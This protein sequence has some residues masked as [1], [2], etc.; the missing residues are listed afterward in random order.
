V[1]RSP[2]GALSVDPRGKAP[3]RGAYLCPDA[4]C[5]ERGLAEGGIA[6][7]LAVAIDASAAQ[8]LRASLEEA[9]RQRSAEVDADQAHSPAPPGS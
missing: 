6:R 4:G 8:E 2:Q 7:A 1:V 3:G 9:S 5:L